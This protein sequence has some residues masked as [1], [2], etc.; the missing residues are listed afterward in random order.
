MSGAEDL[1]RTESAA[2]LAKKIRRKEVSP[3]EV[4]DTAI[5]RIEAHNPKINA[6]V[7]FG[8]DDARKAAK[9][10]EAAIMRGDAVGPLHGVP[11]AMKDCFD[12]KP[13][14]VTTF[15]GI[16]ALKDYVVDTYCMFVERMERA[17]AIFVGKTNSPVVRV[18]RH[19][20]Q[21]SVRAVE[22][23]LRS[24]EEYRRIL[25]RQRRRG[26]GGSLAALRG[27]RRRRLDPHP[28]LLVRRLRLQAVLRARAAG[29]AARGFRRQRALH[30]RRP[31]HPHGGGRRVGDDGA[32]R[33]RFARPLLDRGR[34]GLH[35]RAPR[36]GRRQED[37]L[38][39]R[40]RHL[41]GRSA[42]RCGGRQG[43]RRVRGGGR[44]CRGGGDRHPPLAAGTQRRVVPLHRP[45]AG[46]RA[47]R[48][49]AR[50]HRPRPRPPRRFPAGVLAL[51]R[52]RAA[53]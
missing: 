26:R 45:Q 3:V 52:D 43:G 37:R 38:Y 48:V 32:R 53:A 50:R 20:R 5:A 22:E 16:R 34:G 11:I 49:Q 36:L 14:W 6:L 4:V 31:D 46:R 41:P 12:Y 18:P 10:A 24:D 1:A 19:L 13:G 27:H 25:R 42:R 40:L 8:Y 47:R 21:L 35:G 51:G 15:G 23:P 9:A 2:A 39:A 44:A 28:V 30:L 33:L 17:G 29:D 7:I